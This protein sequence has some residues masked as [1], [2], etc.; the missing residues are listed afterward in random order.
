MK[1]SLVTE[2]GE[3]Y[4][5]R[6]AF[7][8]VALTQSRDAALAQATQQY[9]VEPICEGKKVAPRNSR[10][11]DFY[12]RCEFAAV[13][14]RYGGAEITSVTYH[15]LSAKLVEI[16]AKVAGTAL[17]IHPTAQTLDAMLGDLEFSS[18][19]IESNTGGST[20]LPQAI[21]HWKKSPDLAFVRL[22]TAQSADDEYFE[23]VIQHPLVADVI[24]EL[25]A[26]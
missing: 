8:G 6:P 19:T 12:E 14:K 2:A 11:A 17:D 9:G 4:Q 1:N 23:L 25:P 26:L 22:N 20:G 15:F 5:G 13:S 7:D 10:R 24:A 21:H 3:E 16:D 18:E